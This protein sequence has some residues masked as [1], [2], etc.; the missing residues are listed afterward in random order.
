MQQG[1][2]TVLS[3][4]LGGGGGGGRRGG[5]TNL[6]AHRFDSSSSAFASLTADISFL[7][8]QVATAIASSIKAGDSWP[9]GHEHVRYTRDQLLHL[10]E[11]LEVPNNILKIKQDIEA[12]LFGEVQSWGHTESNPTQQIQNQYSEL[13]NR[14]WRGR[15]GQLPTNPDEFGSRFDSRQQ[16]ASQVNRQGQ[17]NSQFASSYQGGGPTPTLTKAEVPWSN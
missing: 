10:R 11:V 8:P 13:D 9:E 14:D 7:H 1:D 2:Q 6:L 16:D 4:R 15:S 12:E 17:L 5:G 3:L